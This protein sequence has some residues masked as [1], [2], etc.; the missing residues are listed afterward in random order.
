MMVDGASRLAG[1]PAW[2]LWDAPIEHIEPTLA[3]NH[4]SQLLR[5]PNACVI[6]RRGRPARMA[7]AALNIFAERAGTSRRQA[8]AAKLRLGDYPKLFVAFSDKEATRNRDEA[9]ARKGS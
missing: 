1:L 9:I 5:R 2:R 4:E 7:P 8:Q 6:V 3:Q